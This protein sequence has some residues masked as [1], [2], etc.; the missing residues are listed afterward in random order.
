MPLSQKLASNVRSWSLAPQRRQ[1]AR[2][3]GRAT[4]AVAAEASSPSQS[5]SS[6]A[7]NPFP[8][9]TH[10][11]P[12][13]HQIFHLPRNATDADIKVRYY[14]L[15]RLYHPDKPC[16]VSPEIAHERFQA[17]SAAYDVLRGKKL[18]DTLAG[19]SGSTDTRYQTTAAYRAMRRKRQELYDSGAVDDSR[20]DKIILFGVFAT[21]L[22]VIV[23]TATTR[24]EALAEAVAR[25]RH[26]AA[27]QTHSR[28]ARHDGQ[29]SADAGSDNV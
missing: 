18:D 27:S 13:P 9:P 1:I 8:Y 6:A 15:V 29:L 24:R 20:K 28:R 16:G 2:F 26:I 12:S 19:E 5:T 3:S 21:I 14:D 23:N 25:S 22:I 7:Q 17:I 4:H 11:N 10:R